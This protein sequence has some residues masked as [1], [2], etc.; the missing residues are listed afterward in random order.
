MTSITKYGSI[1]SGSTDNTAIEIHSNNKFCCINLSSRKVKVLTYSFIGAAVLTVIILFFKA[2]TNSAYGAQICLEKNRACEID[3]RSLEC[4]TLTN[5]CKEAD[6][7]TIELLSSG[8]VIA[9]SLPILFAIT[10]AIKTYTKW[11][12]TRSYAVI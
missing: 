7:T 4:L 6:R 5:Q 10:K 12:N 8:F 2:L 3:P 9:I 1:D 11:C